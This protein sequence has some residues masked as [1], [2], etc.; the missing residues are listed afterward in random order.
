MNGDVIKKVAEAMQAIVQTTLEDT[1]YKISDLVNS[2]PDR[3][4][5]IVIA[6]MQLTVN[7][8]SAQ[9]NPVEKELYEHILKNTESILLS[10]EFDP[11]KKRDASSGAASSPEGS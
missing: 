5:F 4:R 11:R 9:F 7:S 8:L 1:G 10:A 2:Y 6:S 3:M